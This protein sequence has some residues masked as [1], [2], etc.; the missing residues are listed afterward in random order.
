VLFLVIGHY[1]VQSPRS[2][3]PFD[4]ASEAGPRPNKAPFPETFAVGGPGLYKK[5]LVGE[6]LNPTA[7]KDYAFFIWLKLRKV[8]A[9]GETLGLVGKFDSQVENRPGYA[10]SLE[11][12][13]DGVRPRVYLSAAS[14]GGRWYTFSPYPMSRKYW[15][16]LAVSLS[17]D[18]F[19]SAHIVREGSTDQPTLLGGHRIGLS[20]LPQSA[21]DIVVGAFGAS[22]FRGAIGPFG[23]L[24]GKDLRED[25][26]GYLSAMREEPEGIPSEIDRDAI[27]LWA[28]P[29]KDI[30]PHAF[31]V[32]NGLPVVS[33]S[34]DT[35]A[36][37]VWADKRPNK[38]AAKKKKA[39]TK[40]APKACKSGKTT[41]KP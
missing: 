9:V 5:A 21:S 19:V 10:I 35:Q 32:V 20:S 26:A 40:S 24:V 11:G 30:A 38:S 37:K 18:T 3:W 15:Y 8:P 13:L 25:L 22:R 12:G 27:E 36:K 23:V 17:D 14:G 34:G 31:N 7:G 39:T 4:E 2:F 28:T 6:K 29:N 41:K 1:S 33:A 16:L